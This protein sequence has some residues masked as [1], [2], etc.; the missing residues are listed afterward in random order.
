VK[1]AS[2]GGASRTAGTKE[3]EQVRAE[4]V[5][6]K[7]RESAIFCFFIEEYLFLSEINVQFLHF[8][9]KSLR[10]SMTYCHPRLCFHIHSRI[11]LHF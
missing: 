10:D 3:R 8:L 1:G 11:D 6:V 5:T 7:R 2:L 4:L 9:V